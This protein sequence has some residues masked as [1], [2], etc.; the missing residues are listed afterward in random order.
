[1]KTFIIAAILLIQIADL[2]CQTSITGIVQTNKKQPV[3]GANIYIKNTYEGT[4]SD[5]EGKF[6]LKTD[7]TGAQILVVSFLGYCTHEEPINLD[8]NNIN[9]SIIIHEDQTQ[10]EE[11]DITAG[12]FEASDEKKSA[13]LNTL[14]LATNADGFGDIYLSINSLPGTNTVDDEGGLLVRGGEKYETKTFIDGL[15][16]ESPYTAKLPSVPVR[17]RFSPMLFRGTV[18]STGGYSAEFGQALSS[19]L[20][21]NSVALAEKD[22]TSVAFYSAAMNVTKIKR[23]DNSSFSS[24]SQYNNLAL[25]YRLVTTN[26]NWEDEPESFNETLVYRQKVGKN[27]MLKTMGSYTF[28]KSSMYYLNMNSLEEDFV[29]LKNNNCFIITTYKD[30]L[31]KNWIIHSG[32][33][34]NHDRVNT[35]LND[36]DLEDKN[37]A[38]EFKLVLSNSLH[39]NVKIKFGGNIYRKQYNRSYYLEREDTIL[40]WKF[41]N[42][43]SSAFAETDIKVSKRIAARIGARFEFLTLTDEIYISPRLSLAYKIFKNSQI[44][45][46]YGQFLQQPVDNNLLY[47]N[48]L[49][50]EQAEHFILNYQIFKNSRI[51]RIESYYKDYSNLVMYDS[52]YA[53]DPEAYNN[54]GNGYARGI[55]IFYRDQKSIKNGD[56]WFSYSFMDSKRYYKDYTSSLTPYFISRHNLSIQYKHYIE[57]FDAYVGANYKYA[58]GR[59]YINPNLG[60]TIQEWTRSYHSLGIN[61]F[62]FTEVFGKFT[63][64]HIHITNILGFNNIYG[65]RY[66]K[67][68]DAEGIYEAYPIVP[69]SK[70]FFLVGIYFSLQG[71]PVI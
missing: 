36:D 33:S 63:M 51:F 31:S 32:I 23:W 8:S 67:Y 61:I 13:I 24:I 1:M 2:Y 15:L 29:S 55:D 4:T 10:L 25:T 14:D 40:N 26:V 71:R 43:I 18:F 19:A 70:R 56:F 28:D 59:P 66:T 6:V 22:E 3:F 45:L 50:S 20:I 17:G 37:L 58:S 65:Y 12:V 47:N 38:N 44:S 5:I 16:V 69:V 64:F 21:L 27:G 39:E 30:E 11:V 48:N 9:L 41:I 52:L 49:K 60:N 54:A 35:G 42:T 62:H 53:I 34:F 68:P 7:L 57:K 46:A